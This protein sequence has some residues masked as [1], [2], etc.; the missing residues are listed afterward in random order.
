MP[1][2]RIYPVVLIDALVEKIR[3]GQVANRPVYVAVGIN[4]AGE[5]DVLGLWVGTGGE[6]APRRG[7]PPWPSCAT[8]VSK[9][10]ASWPATG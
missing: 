3:D 8:A 10:C 1:L 7:W 2:D 9:T 4:L 6:G 5:R